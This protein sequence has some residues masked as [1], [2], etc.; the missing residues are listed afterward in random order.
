MSIE[1][2]SK[3]VKNN[4]FATVIKNDI[5]IN[6][7]CVLFETQEK[8]LVTRHILTNSDFLE[9]YKPYEPVYEY[10]YA[11]ID[12]RGEAVVSLIYF[13]NEKDFKNRIGNS[14]K[15]LQRLDFTKRERT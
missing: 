13:I 3:W 12:Y 7:F 4:E 1:V 2:G 11:F 8:T 5:L 15:F 10:K 9:Q 14:V 6:L